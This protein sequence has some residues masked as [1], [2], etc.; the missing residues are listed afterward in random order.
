VEGIRGQVGAIWERR[1]GGCLL[2]GWNG[3]GVGSWNGN[4]VGTGVGGR[5]VGVPCPDECY[6]ICMYQIRPCLAH[7]SFGT[8][9][10]PRPTDS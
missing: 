10:N 7:S 5:I 3:D 8:A 4:G 1:P 9:T 2:R 6:C